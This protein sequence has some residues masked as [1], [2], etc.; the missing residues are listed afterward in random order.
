MRVAFFPKIP[1]FISFAFPL[2]SQEPPPQPLETTASELVATAADETEANS[3]S[4]K[5]QRRF[6]YP[7]GSLQRVQTLTKNE[8]G[9]FIEHGVEVE[10]FENGKL[11]SR[12]LIING[13]KVGKWVS[14]DEQLRLT[15]GE[16]QDG[17]RSGSWKV[18]T[19]DKQLISHEQF[20]GD[21][22]HGPQYY[23]HPNGKI[24]RQIFYSRGSK[25]GVERHWYVKGIKALEIN[26]VDGLQSGEAH[27]WFEDGTLILKGSY[28]MGIPEGKWEWYKLNGELLNSSTFTKG[29]GTLYE[30]AVVQKKDSEERQMALMKEVSYSEGRQHGMEILYFPGGQPKSETH[31][32]KGKKTGAFKER[33]AEGSLKKE[34]TYKDGFLVGGLNVY[35]PVEKKELYAL[36]VLAKETRYHE[37]SSVA[38]VIEYTKEGKKQSE[39]RLENDLPD[40]DF[41][42]FYPDGVVMRRGSFS[43]GLKHGSWE[44]F[45]SDG[46]KRSTQEF[47]LDK[48]HGS[49]HVWFEAIADADPILKLEGS[50]AN[51]EKEG[52][53][54]TWYPDGS[55][56]SKVSFRFGAEDGEYKEW[57]PKFEENEG[58][59]V[60][61]RTQGQFILGKKH[62]E[63]KIWHANGLLKS[64]GIFVH[65]V[66]D[67]P[68]EEW[69]EYLIEGEP[70]LKLNGSYKNG[71]QH[72]KWNAYFPDGKLEISQ[73]YE[74]GMLQ[75]FVKQYYA[76]AVLKSEAF[77]DKG[78]QEGEANLYYP[79]SKLKS[80]TFFFKNRKH[81]PFS[82]YNSDG[83]V[84]TTGAYHL[85]IPVGPWEWYEKDGKSIMASTVFEKGKG[86]MYEFYPNERKKMEAEYLD[87]R[88]HG[89]QKRWYDTGSLRSEA[90]FYHGL[91]HGTYKEYH[92]SGNPLVEN[93]WIYG[94]RNGSYLSWYGNEQQQLSLFFVD[95]QP[96][97]QS[98][99]WYE[100]GNLKSG[101]TWVQGK[102]H[103][104]W[105]WYDR[106][107]AD[108][109]SQEYDLGILISSVG[110]EE[111]ALE[112]FAK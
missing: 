83:E 13:K 82:F 103:G 49:F 29:N 7:S 40:G 25:Q 80:K 16:Y 68:V 100:N 31:Y 57:W 33:Y 98:T 10:F 50:F 81:G 28:F 34:G 64:R 37:G 12:G 112:Q 46:K 51:G 4:V 26:W 3:A 44:D 21:L 55:L 111:K 107:G 6:F 18:W 52:L 2:F 60:Q 90:T 75:G 15:Q 59:E 99:E 30:Y 62:G 63:W 91:I 110:D 56:E 109:L 1:L 93:S 70:S 27:R 45:Y 41:T 88:G 104:T 23:Y 105:K 71:K 73:M 65:G 5:V 67:G 17:L 38:E 96:H 102:R 77:F 32:A 48:E 87:G 92:E 89:Q 47:V 43:K 97:G 9:S 106:Y 95:D 84:G 8:D 22:L 36:P 85:G 61:M 108:I 76:T 86:T 54:T 58:D 78:E 24:A 72:G 20:L 79:N 35:Y 101:G 66:Q 14:I 19:V 11:K 53:W 69:H 94:R 42:A 74:E 39:M